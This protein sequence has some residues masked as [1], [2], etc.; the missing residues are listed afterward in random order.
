L[1]GTAQIA[2]CLAAA[3][4]PESAREVRRDR[5]RLTELTERFGEV[6]RTGA[7][8]PEEAFARVLV[9]YTSGDSAARAWLTDRLRQAASSL[10]SDGVAP[11]RGA[12][13]AAWR[14]LI[15]AAGRFHAS[16]V[17]R[18]PTRA[19][20]NR[21]DLDALVRE[22]HRQRP[23]TRARWTQYGPPGPVLRR[24]AID[25]RLQRAATRALGVRLAPA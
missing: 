19:F 24:L 1:I 10:A 4:S 8:R 3:L 5:R 16:G 6:T 11:Q 25:R 21:G 20:L 2:T 14:A 7:R 15:I 13:A 23:A 12:R 18:L 17:R 9:G 22:G